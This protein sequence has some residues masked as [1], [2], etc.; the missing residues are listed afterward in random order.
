MYLP[1]A[2]YEALP[3][4]YVAAGTAVAAIMEGSVAVGSGAILILAGTLV[5]MMRRRNRAA[6]VASERKNARSRR[7]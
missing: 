1:E 4:V 2:A 5:L 6:I 3:Y 7:R